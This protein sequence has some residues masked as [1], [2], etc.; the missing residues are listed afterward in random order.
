MAHAVV[1]VDQSGGGTTLEDA[2]VGLPASHCPV[3]AALAVLTK[4]TGLAL[5]LA[6]PLAMLFTLRL[7]VLKRPVLWVAVLIVYRMLEKEFGI[8]FNQYKPQIAAAVKAIQGEY[9]GANV[10]HRKAA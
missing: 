5:A 6:A 9:K 7:S 10:M 2:D 8:D 1:A 4:G 3:L